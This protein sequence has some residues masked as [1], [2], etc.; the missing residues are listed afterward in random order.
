MFNGATEHWYL[1]LAPSDSWG[2][3]ELKRKRVAYSHHEPLE[4]GQEEIP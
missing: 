2:K 4:S 1:Y 3:D